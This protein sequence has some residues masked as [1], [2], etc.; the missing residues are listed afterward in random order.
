[1]ARLTAFNQLRNYDLS[2]NYIAA[3]SH[4]TDLAMQANNALQTSQEV[5]V[6]F[7]NTRIGR[8]LKQGARLI[9]K[10]TDLSITRQIFYCQLGGFDT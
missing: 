5:T 6:T 3:A 4:I 9:K 2:S 1:A 10:R 7:P 8:Q